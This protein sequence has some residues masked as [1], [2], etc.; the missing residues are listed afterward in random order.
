MNLLVIADDESVGSQIPDCSKARRP[1][2]RS[3]TL[4]WLPEYPRHDREAAK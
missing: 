2:V 1:A 3:S 4:P